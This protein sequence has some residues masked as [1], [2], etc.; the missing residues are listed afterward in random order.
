MEHVLVGKVKAATAS[1][2][3]N[4]QL[5]RVSHFAL[6]MF[7]DSRP[8]LILQWEHFLFFLESNRFCV[9]S[10]WGLYCPY[11]TCKP[12]IHFWNLMERIYIDKWFNKLRF[13]SEYCSICRKHKA[14]K[15]SAIN[16]PWRL[17][18]TVEFICMVCSHCVRHL[19][20]ASWPLWVTRNWD[21]M[22]IF[23]TICYPYW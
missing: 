14:T 23:L 7:I 10:I 11:L 3:Q 13:A 4:R 1:N 9:C 17:L 21:E 5:I 12:Q 6:L 22:I 18:F 2:Y 15:W 8:T 19:F 16:D 20:F